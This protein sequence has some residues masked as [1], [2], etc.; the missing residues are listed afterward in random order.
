MKKISFEE[1]KSIQYELLKEIH[2]FCEKN[3]L[4]YFLG[5]GTLIG[6]IRHN[7]YIPWDDDIDIFMPYNDFLTLSSL[8]VS[9]KYSIKSCMKTEGY[10]SPIGR[11]YDNR[12][13][14]IKGP[15]ITLGL[16]IDIYPLFGA[17]KDEII[18]RKHCELLAKYDKWRRILRKIRNGLAK[19]YL[20]PK[21]TM[22]FGLLHKLC[23]RM[24]NQYSKYSFD[25][26]DYVIIGGAMPKPYDKVLFEKRE[27]HV[28]EDR[29]FYIPTEYHRLLLSQY[30]DYMKLPPIKERK[31]YHGVDHCCWK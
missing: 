12:T 1:A 15:F 27:L 17:P 10:G 11:I 16:S 28:F 22:A 26:T 21:R 20:W 25:D 23:V 4:T 8:Y 5:F 2:S 31:P 7:G 14:S 19:Y 29:E 13:I 18:M 24:I 9:D 6:A 30:G 3:N